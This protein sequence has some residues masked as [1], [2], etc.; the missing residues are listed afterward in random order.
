MDCTV[1]RSVGQQTASV[2][3]QI[4]DVSGFPDYAVSVAATHSIFVAWEQPQTVMNAC[5]CVLAGV[6][7]QIRQAKGQFTFR[8]RHFIT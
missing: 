1:I 2:K 7:E 3:N 6:T 5:G 8:C 4:E